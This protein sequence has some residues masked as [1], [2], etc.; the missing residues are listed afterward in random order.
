MINNGVASEYEFPKFDPM[1]CTIQE[2]TMHWKDYTN[3]EPIWNE[4]RDEIF[5]EGKKDTFNIMKN[6]CKHTHFTYDRD[7][8]CSG[9]NYC[10]LKGFDC[11]CCYEN[12]DLMKEKTNER[13]GI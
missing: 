8:H 10:M 6:N 9:Y 7:S 2:L 4:V 13:N 1:T 11:V 5:Q 12:C 3:S